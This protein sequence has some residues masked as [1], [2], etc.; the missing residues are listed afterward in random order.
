M[1][2]FIVD[3]VEHNVFKGNKVT[4]CFDQITLTGRHQFFKRVFFVEGNN[5]IAHFIVGCV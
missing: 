3:A 5:L 4:G 1:L 2:R